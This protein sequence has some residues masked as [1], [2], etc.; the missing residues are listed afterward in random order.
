MEFYTASVTMSIGASN[1]AEGNITRCTGR[2]RNARF[3]ATPPEGAASG[4]LLA[5]MASMEVWGQ[6]LFALAACAIVSARRGADM[7]GRGRWRCD[8]RA[9]VIM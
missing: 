3:V 5:A 4:A 6:R 1:D 2:I 7:Y 8:L 9:G